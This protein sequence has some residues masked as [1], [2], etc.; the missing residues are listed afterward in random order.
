MFALLVNHLRCESPKIGFMT[1][2]QLT[3]IYSDAHLSMTTE[4]TGLANEIPK[5]YS[6]LPTYEDGWLWIIEPPI[7]NIS[8][9]QDVV[10]CNE[11]IALVNSITHNFVSIKLN[12]E[13]VPTVGN[14]GASS[15]WK[16]ICDNSDVLKQDLE[17]QLYNEQHKCYLTSN[18]SLLSDTEPNKFK[19][20]CKEQNKYSIWAIKEGVFFLEPKPVQKQEN[21]YDDDEL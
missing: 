8:K 12:K 2:A 11:S 21:E 5:I 10:K 20:T 3:N 6:S 13:V 9:G 17:F 15:K 1:T 14:M 7:E 16:L 18:F 4:N 19:I